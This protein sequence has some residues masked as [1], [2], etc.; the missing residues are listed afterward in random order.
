MCTC[1][2]V[3]GSLRS[4]RQLHQ[5][6]LEKVVRL[7]MSFFDTQ[8]SG[9]LLNRFSRDTE[10]LDTNLGQARPHSNSHTAV[11]RASGQ[12]T[13]MLLKQVWHVM[14]EALRRPACSQPS[15]GLKDAFILWRNE[16]GS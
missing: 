5:R 12:Q 6:L 4:G 11:L 15:L 2:L 8:P 10:A 7:P 3:F 14:F 1:S 16:G 9:R 13:G